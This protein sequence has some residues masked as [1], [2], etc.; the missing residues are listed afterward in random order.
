MIQEKENTYSDCLL[1]I[2]YNK[3]LYI[4]ILQAGLNILSNKIIIASTKTSVTQM[5]TCLFKTMNQK[6]VRKIIDGHKYFPNQIYKE[7]LENA[8]NAAF[9]IIL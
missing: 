1:S 9:P 4:N 5:F 7:C 6:T 3:N 2:E 8:F